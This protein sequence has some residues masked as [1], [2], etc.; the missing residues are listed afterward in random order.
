MEDVRKSIQSS[1]RRVVSA[2]TGSFEDHYDS[3][4]LYLSCGLTVFRGTYNRD[5]S[6]CVDIFRWDADGNSFDPNKLHWDERKKLVKKLYAAKQTTEQI[7]LFLD[8]TDRMLE[9]D[10]AD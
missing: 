10:S 7:K 5:G 1:I 9:R 2:L 3:S 4:E 8:L 6:T